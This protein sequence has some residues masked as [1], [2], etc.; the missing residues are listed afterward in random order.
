MKG[1]RENLT[2]AMTMR[3]EYEILY[4]EEERLQAI[5]KTLPKENRKRLD[6]LDKVTNVTE[7]KS[8]LLKNKIFE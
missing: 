1:L 5:K 3:F 7:T 4:S 2:A 8:V 6:D